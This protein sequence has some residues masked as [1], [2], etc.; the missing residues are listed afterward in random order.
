MWTSK[1]ITRMLDDELVNAWRA[2]YDVKD[3]E[4]MGTAMDVYQAVKRI[5]ERAHG[6]R[7]S[8]TRDGVYELRRVYA[9]VVRMPKDNMRQHYGGHKM[10]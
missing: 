1:A 8:V 3:A 4:K 5:V 9:P 7:V 6:C 10:H 2:L